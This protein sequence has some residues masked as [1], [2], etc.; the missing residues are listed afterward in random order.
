M[1]ERLQCGYPQN[2]YNFVQKHP[3]QR[4]TYESMEISFE[5][6]GLRQLH[7]YTQSYKFKSNKQDFR[8]A[9]ET[10]LLLMTLWYYF[11]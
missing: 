8:F 5:L 3:I 9:T 4:S 1:Q 7:G 11:N 10:H 2:E 6:N